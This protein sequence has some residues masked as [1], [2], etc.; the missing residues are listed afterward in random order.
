[1]ENSDDEFGIERCIDTGVFPITTPAARV[2]V[3][4]QPPSATAVKYQ[5]HH[6][7]TNRPVHLENSCQVRSRSVAGCQG[8]E[9]GCARDLTEAF[10]AI[11]ALTSS[12]LASEKLPGEL[13]VSQ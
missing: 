13:L 10:P 6:R 7:D 4:L 3:C 2:S 12:P 1:M 9:S 5:L 8:C 11:L